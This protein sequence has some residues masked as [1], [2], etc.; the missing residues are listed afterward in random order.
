MWRMKVE[1]LELMS[2]V[3]V[4]PGRRCRSST[5]TLGLAVYMSTRESWSSLL[6]VHVG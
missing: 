1:P 6:G 4:S 2:W 5:F 3:L